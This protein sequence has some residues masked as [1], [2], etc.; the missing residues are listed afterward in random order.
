M[1]GA[2]TGTPGGERA[3]ETGCSATQLDQRE[4]RSQARR[5]EQE[6]PADKT[7]LER[8]EPAFDHADAGQ[9]PALDARQAA[10]QLALE[11]APQLGHLFPQ[12]CSE[13]RDPL[14]QLR[15]ESCEVGLEEVAEL[16]AIGGVHLIEPLHEL[17]GQLVAEPVV[18][19]A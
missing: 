4:Q 11:F 1:R 5:P 7:A 16:E 18:E 9:Q 3:T 10:P 15:V 2:R 8:A 13:L 6:L 14:F 12:L 19:R 17:I